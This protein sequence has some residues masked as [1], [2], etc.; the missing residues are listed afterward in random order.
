MNVE[1]V[2]LGIERFTQGGGGRVG[3]R[4]RQVNEK[5]G[6]MKNPRESYSLIII[7]GSCHFFVCLP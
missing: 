7:Y 3:N 6:Y 1:D 4:R 2:I 5:E